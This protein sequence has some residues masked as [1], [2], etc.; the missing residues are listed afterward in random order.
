MENERYLREHPEMSTLLS[1]FVRK[2]LDE[3][4]NNILEYAGQF[5]DRAEL[6]DVVERAMEDEKEE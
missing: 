1:L 2:V 6:K 3:R 5:F 4:P